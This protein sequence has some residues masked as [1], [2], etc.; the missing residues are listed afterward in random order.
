LIENNDFQKNASDPLFL[1][2]LIDEVEAHTRLPRQKILAMVK[3]Y[4]NSE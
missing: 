2:A 1:L 4:L 3:T